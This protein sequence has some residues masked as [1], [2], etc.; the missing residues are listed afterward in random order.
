MF[1]FGEAPK[2]VLDLTKRSP[3][4]DPLMKK[5]KQRLV[6]QEEAAVVLVDM[7]SVHLAGLGAPGRPAGNAL[8]LA[9]RGPARR[10]QWRRYAKA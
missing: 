10:T 7:V 6:G 3:I 4:L 5:M 1:G 9:L 2:E 8:F